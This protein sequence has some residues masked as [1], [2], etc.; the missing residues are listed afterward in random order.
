[1]HGGWHL[2]ARS[3]GLVRGIPSKGGWKQA[4]CY[5]QNTHRGKGGKERRERGGE[6]GSWVLPEMRAFS[7]G[8]KMGWRGQSRPAVT[9]EPPGKDSRRSCYSRVPVFL[10]SFSCLQDPHCMRALPGGRNEWTQ[11][12]CL[13][14]HDCVLAD[15]QA[16]KL[17]CSLISPLVSQ[18]AP[19]SPSCVLFLS[20]CRAVA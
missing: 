6:I 7:V 5:F 8:P 4:F 1:M 14:Q 16:E 13:T 2:R 17:F 12:C 15:L 10:L 3:P 20:L 19:S 18:L 11:A 9:D